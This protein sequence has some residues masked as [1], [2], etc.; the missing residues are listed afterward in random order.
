MVSEGLSGI[1][2]FLRASKGVSEMIQRWFKD[3]QAVSG[4]L[5][6][7]FLGYSWCI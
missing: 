2:G 7:G 3:F 1:S 6:R 4:G 5:R